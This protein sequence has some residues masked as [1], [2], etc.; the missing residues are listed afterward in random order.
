[1]RPPTE[2]VVR[3]EAALGAVKHAQA[4]L[5]GQLDE[6]NGEHTIL[7]AKAELSL[8]VSEHA[9]VEAGYHEPPPLPHTRDPASRAE[10]PGV[11][12]STGVCCAFMAFVV[13]R[14]MVV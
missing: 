1:V 5:A 6:A 9:R 11:R 14:V 10:R 2:G 8:L 13:L 12:D 7:A 3:A 4:E